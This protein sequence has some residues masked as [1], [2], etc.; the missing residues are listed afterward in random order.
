MEISL[1]TTTLGI[2]DLTEIP[3]IINNLISSG[4]EK[5]EVLNSDSKWFGVTYLEDKKNVID[6][7]KKLTDNNTYPS[8]LF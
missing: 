7:I 4:K 6:K 1:T 8:P 5:I 2:K 3:T